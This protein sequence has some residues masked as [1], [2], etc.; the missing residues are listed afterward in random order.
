MLTIPWLVVFTCVRTCFPGRTVVFEGRDLLIHVLVTPSCHTRLRA[1]CVPR[2]VSRTVVLTPVFQT[3][4]LFQSRRKTPVFIFT[5]LWS[6]LGWMTTLS[7]RRWRDS[8]DM[9][10]AVLRLSQGVTHAKPPQLGVHVEWGW[11]Q[12]LN[13]RWTAGSR[14]LHS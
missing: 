9:G 5:T 11:A 13:A 8:G 2:C 14:V 7:C 3:E 12:R 6:T 10:S 1:L 4:G